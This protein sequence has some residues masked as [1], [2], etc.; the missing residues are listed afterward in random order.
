MQKRPVEFIKNKIWGPDTGTPGRPGSFFVRPARLF[1]ATA[2]DIYEGQLTL[3]ATSLAY[4]TLVSLIPLLAVSFS[5]LKAFGVHYQI[6][7]LLYRFFSPLGTKGAELTQKIISFVD[8]VN[9]GVLGSIGIATLIYTAVSVIQKVEN[10]FNYI[11]RVS[12]PRSFARRFSDYTSILIIGP[13][14]I[15]SAIGITA[16]VMN[17]G[18]AKKLFALEPFG[19]LVYAASRM[20][21]YIFVSA[22]FTFIYFF[23]PNTRVKVKSALAGGITAGI[24]WQTSG[25]AFATFTASSKQY[26][27]IYS[28]F[29]IVIL[30]M[31][32]IYLSWLILLAGA[33]ISFYHQHPQ[34]L[35]VKRGATITSSRMREKLALS[36][37]LLTGYSYYHNTR[38]WTYDTLI[39]RLNPAAEPVREVL[40]AL[41]AKGLLIETCDNPPLLIPGRDIETITQKEILGSVRYDGNGSTGIRCASGQGV[42]SIMEKIDRAV[43]TALGPDTL[44]TLVLS[45]REFEER[46]QK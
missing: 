32:W 10:A 28:G 33:S 2:R 45:C 40:N 41:I 35:S 38:P 3:Q 15:V 37:M 26:S 20:L 43:E 8:N 11:W 18:F 21:P 23:L 4:T 34:L 31:I 25:W 1:Y 6:M 36:I 14:L 46:D 9:A 19:A 39:N 30:F 7:P 24:L 29:A 42:D 16:S 13:V 5:V 44:K 17:S 22:A 27:A 12:R